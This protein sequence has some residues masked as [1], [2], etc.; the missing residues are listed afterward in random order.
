MGQA[1]LQKG[2]GGRDEEKLFL[3]SLCRKLLCDALR[4][5]VRGEKAMCE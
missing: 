5:D 4:R 1:E 3:G 2:G